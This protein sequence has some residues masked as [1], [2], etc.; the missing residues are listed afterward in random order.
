MNRSSPARLHVA[1]DIIVA[2]L[3]VASCGAFAGVGVGL[4]TGVA[5]IAAGV[6]LLAVPSPRT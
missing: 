6:L 5:W 4:H 1:H 2:G 3:I